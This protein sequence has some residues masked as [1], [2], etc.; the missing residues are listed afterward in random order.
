[1]NLP[2]A[3]SLL[4]TN[5]KGVQILIALQIVDTKDF[6]SKLFL[7]EVFD[8]FWMV[9]GSIRT[10]STFLLDGHLNHEFY[11]TDE[12]EE[13]QM[14]EQPYVAWRT[15]RPLCFD[16]IKGKKTPLSFKFSFR[17]STSNTEKLLQQSGIALSVSDINGLFLNIRYQEGK[18]LLTTGTSL[19][20]FTLDK[21]LDYAWDTMVQRFL[22]Q[23]EIGFTQE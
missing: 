21:S 14:K 1:M 22:K 16:L 18:V 4:Q 17:L 8:S 7:Q 5:Y 2:I 19:R 15:L 23:K 10:H 20:L 9:E 11:S 3:S 12:L 6:T 13:Q